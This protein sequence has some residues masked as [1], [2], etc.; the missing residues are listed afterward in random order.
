[1]GIQLAELNIKELSK[2]RPELQGL[3]G[4]P[5]ARNGLC[6]LCAVLGVVRLLARRPNV[7]SVQVSEALIEAFIDHVPCS[8]RNYER[9]HPACV[10]WRWC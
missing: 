6:H 7:R 10:H 5:E 1:M 8:C 9:L 2:M 4:A 3:K